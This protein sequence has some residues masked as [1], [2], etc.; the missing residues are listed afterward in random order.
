MT[1]PSTAGLPFVW[2]LVAT[3]AFVAGLQLLRSSL[4]GLSVYL[5]QVHDVSPAL[6]AILIFAIFSTA[7]AA[8]LVRRTLRTPGAFLSLAAVLALLRLAEQFTPDLDARL[9][10]AI[11]GVVVWLWF[12]PLLFARGSGDETRVGP[13]GVL[14]LVLGLTVDTTIKG[15]FGTLDLSSAP[16]LAPQ[17]TTIA[18]TVALLS[19]ALWLARSEDDRLT[20]G[21]EPKSAFV[22]GPAIALHLLIFQ[23]LGHHAALIGWSLPAVF[24]WTT[25]ANLIAL[26][27][28][29]GMSSGK[30]GMTRWMSIAA[31]I[32]LFVAIAPSPPAWLSAIGALL[33]P[34]AIAIL[35]FAALADRGEN[36]SGWPGM[37]IGMLAIPVVLFGWYAHYEIDIPIPQWVLPLAAAALI[38]GPGLASARDSHVSDWS[39]ASFV[40]FGALL[41]LLLPLHQFLSWNDPAAPPSSERLRVATY[42]I[43]QGFDLY[44]RHDLEG[45]AQAIEDAQPQIVALQEVPRGWVVNGSV[46]AL[47]WLAQRLRMHAAWGSA[48]DANWGNAILSRYPIVDV[49]N[50]P[51]P[52]NDDLLFH[53]A[54]MIAV[55][56]LGDRQVQVVATH[57]HHIERESRHRIPQVRELLEQID[58]TRPTI[59]LGDLNAQPH[60]EEIRLL[61]SAGLMTVQPP[62]ATYPAHRPR[63]QIDY[64]LTTV[65]FAVIDVH[66][67]PTT[68]SDHLPLVATLEWQRALE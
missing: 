7:F 63:R 33:G 48:A 11:A 65:H 51:M 68:A 12:I 2:L 27:L 53:R 24:A 61:T 56:D 22:V 44:G 3:L 29:I 46:D 43:H 54:Y 19:L 16:G 1:K 41:M 15:V 37:A 23:N 6:L 21:G 49:V 17:L 18:L 57:L 66:A 25:V 9:A 32:A 55:I 67:P 38:A 35:L 28:V 42:N 20:G 10:I 8:P 59:L 26:W 52:N 39:G 31:A 47:S 5:G 40:G 50:R 45:I 36:R 64:V 60:H 30:F 13:G 62:V 4:S 58:W 14:A 34:P